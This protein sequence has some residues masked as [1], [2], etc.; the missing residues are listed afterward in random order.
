MA[1]ALSFDDL[2]PQQAAPDG[3]SFDD[4]IPKKSAVPAPSQ[5]DSV[6]FDQNGNPLDTSVTDD[7][8]FVTK[9][10]KK[11]DGIV[12]ML[13]NGATLGFGDRIAAAGDSL[14]I[15]GGKF[16]DYSG[17]LAAERAKDAAVRA[18][19]PYTA[20]GAEIAGGLIAPLGLAGKVMEGTNL[21]SNIARGTV[22]GAGIGG[23]QGAAASQD[24]SDLAD[25]GANAIHGASLGAAFGGG[26]P[27]LGSAA[28]S[29]YRTVAPFLGAASPDGMS[30]AAG[31]ILSNVI[32]PETAAR[33][34]QLGP[35]GMIADTSPS[36]L[37]VIQGIAAKGG[38]ASDI[39]VG[40]LADRAGGQSDR[41]L[42]SLDNNLGPAFSPRQVQSMME[43]KQAAT[44]PIY[45]N[46]F[47]NAPPI[48]DT[49]AVQ[50][51]LDDVSATA[52]GS[53]AKDL[54]S[55]QR[56]LEAPYQRN[57]MTIPEYDPRALHGAKEAMDVAIARTEGQTGSEAAKATRAMVQVRSALNNALE[58]QVPG[59]A[60]ANLAYRTAARGGE[61]FDAGR[62]AL[63]GGANTLW[64]VD[65]DN[66]FA[67]LPLE[68]QALMRSGAR[69]DIQAGLGTNPNDLSAL[70]KVVG[71]ENDFNR[72]KM[73]TL[74]G[75]EQTQNVIRDVDA[76]RTFAD[77]YGKVAQGSQ[78]AQR[79]RNADMLNAAEAPPQFVVPKTASLVGLAG[80][81]GEYL[82]RKGFGALAKATGDSTREQL[83]RALTT[84][85]PEA[86]TTIQ[87]LARTLMNYGQNAETIKGAVSNPQSI[88]AALTG[89]QQS[90]RK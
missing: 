64:P 33:L 31:G 60:E 70:K 40:N 32:T 77:T 67:P 2:I 24:L 88:A 38:P 21:A 72:P 28:G 22:A 58:T 82:I 4:L 61:A 89:Y 23:L 63:K 16:G 45:E 81:G 3:L 37:G 69:S 83:A 15:N 29:A 34:E 59:Y 17:N 73:E 11:L 8:A 7:P 10:E 43:A 49:S 71:G 68:Q 48:I 53:V 36:A 46:A 41:L 18:D 14:G 26:I 20:A 65:L 51:V 75:P 55:F 87:D 44:S 42:S 19:M 30:R 74:F 85:G 9:N 12:R 13:A 66:Q 6:N 27:A 50:R 47:R 54:G 1:D 39:A 79:L 80:H 57:G 84:P 56:L 76:E 5:T 52:K 86:A 90:N 78:S 25:T 35:N 62:Q